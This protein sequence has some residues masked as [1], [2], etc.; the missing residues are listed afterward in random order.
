MSYGLKHVKLNLSGSHGNVF[1]ILGAAKGLV[2]KVEG[3][4][5]ANEFARQADGTAWRE[6]GG[7]WS[8]NDVLRT[9][10]DKIGLTFVADGELTDVDKDLYELNDH[11]EVWI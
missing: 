6:M 8:Y 3:F 11:K 7:D 1:H 5:A 10:K 9:V 2:R 4:K